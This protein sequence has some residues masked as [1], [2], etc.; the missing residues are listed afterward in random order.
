MTPTLLAEYIAAV[1]IT[2]SALFWVNM[3]I[4]GMCGVFDKDESSKEKDE[5]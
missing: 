3:L 4:A 5:E 2:V 1:G